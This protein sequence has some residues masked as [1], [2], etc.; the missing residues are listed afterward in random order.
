MIVVNSD[1]YL[2][3]IIISVF[4]YDLSCSYGRKMRRQGAVTIFFYFH[5][6]LFLSFTISS[7]TLFSL[8]PASFNASAVP[9]PQGHNRCMRKFIL[10]AFDM[11]REIQI[12]PRRISYARE[13]EAELYE[14]L[15]AIASSKQDEIRSVIID[16]IANMSEDLLEKAAE[17]EFQ[18]ESAGS[19]V[20]VCGVGCSNPSLPRMFPELF[21]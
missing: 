19:R 1:F 20:F 2:V 18:G 13:K 8:P 7:M 14:N 5:F 9:H 15:M 16:T 17:Y 11:A 12:T 10:Y 4:V 3:L 6:Y 21:F